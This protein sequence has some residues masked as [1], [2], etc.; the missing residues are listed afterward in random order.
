MDSRT[1]NASIPFALAVIAIVVG[2]LVDHAIVL[3]VCF[4]FL[5][6][7][8]PVCFFVALE[9]IR[10][11]EPPE[12]SLSPLMPTRAERELRRNLRNRR[13]LTD[14][15][16][17]SACY[18]NS[19]VSK[20]SIASI[21]TILSEQIGMDLSALLPHDDLNL[22]DPELEWSIIIDEFEREFEIRFTDSEL[23][24]GPATF[25]FFVQHLINNK[26]CPKSPDNQRM[27][28]S[29]RQRGN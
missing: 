3:S 13:K 9:W 15:E 20:T 12:I 1:F 6:F 14:D 19:G 27:N 16:F 18:A 22:I 17:Y 5:V 25:D 24:K 4:A 29:R 2:L 7:V 10:H 11:R 26:P 8:I 23:E 28:R 21:R